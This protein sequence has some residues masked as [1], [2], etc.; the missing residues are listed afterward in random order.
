[1]TVFPSS[2]LSV[3]PQRLVNDGLVLRII[4]CKLTKIIASGMAEKM[5]SAANSGR[6]VKRLYLDMA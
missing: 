3:Y 2:S 6:K 1:M 5:F 4:P